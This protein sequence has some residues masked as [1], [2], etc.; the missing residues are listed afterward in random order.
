VKKKRKPRTKGYD[1]CTCGNANCDPFAHSNPHFI[2]KREKRFKEKL[3][4]GC[5][6]SPC[7]CRSKQ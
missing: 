7:N 1:L 3:C 6:K 2:R 4:L 5:G